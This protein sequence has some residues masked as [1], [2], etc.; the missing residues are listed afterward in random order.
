LEI[1][2]SRIG[3]ILSLILI[4]ATFVAYESWTHLAETTANST[5]EDLS[6][7]DI[8][9][10]PEDY[11]GDRNATFT[12]TNIAVREDPEHRL[13]E[14]YYLV[15]VKDAYGC[16]MP[17]VIS[18]EDLPRYELRLGKQAMFKLTG[19]KGPGLIHPPDTLITNI[20]INK[21]VDQYSREW[22]TIYI[23]LIDP[24]SSST[25]Q[26]SSNMSLI[27]ISI[28]AVAASVVLIAYR[29]TKKRVILTDSPKYA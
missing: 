17:F 2:S 14:K 11:L 23:T 13:K 18:E 15:Y 22:Y 21:P 19:R 27:S 1:N 4:G 7:K 26:L 20:L 3:M 5:P 6:L 9:E 10:R 8:A 24:P 28:V 12:V 25:N 29:R 16:V